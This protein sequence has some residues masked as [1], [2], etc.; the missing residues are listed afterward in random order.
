VGKFIVPYANQLKCNPDFIIGVA[1]E[2]LGST[3]K[4]PSS[5]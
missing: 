5:T 4:N 3:I 1:V 2:A